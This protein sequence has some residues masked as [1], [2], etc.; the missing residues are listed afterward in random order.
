MTSFDLVLSRFK[1]LNFEIDPCAF[2]SLLIGHERTGC[3]L[4]RG[5]TDQILLGP[6]GRLLEERLNKK[7]L[8]VHRYFFFLKILFF[9]FLTHE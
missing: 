6:D 1:V 7:P 8:Q 9:Y 3:V 5:R 4:D 2:H